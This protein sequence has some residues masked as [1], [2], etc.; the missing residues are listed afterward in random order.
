MPT[1][2]ALP[3]A[4]CGTALVQECLGPCLTWET[5]GQPSQTVA[6]LV[7][8]G[9]FHYVAGRTENEFLYVTMEPDGGSALWRSIDGGAP[10]EITSLPP[11]RLSMVSAMAAG[12]YGTWLV[13]SILSNGVNTNA[14]AYIVNTTNELAVASTKTQ[15]LY[16]TSNGVAR[17]SDYYVALTDGLYS[18]YPAG[19]S[20]LYFNPPTDSATITSIAVDDAEQ[21][22]YFVRGGSG[23]YA[24]WH[25]SFATNEATVLT[26]LPFDLVGYAM[27]VNALAL[28]DGW[29]YVLGVR[30]LVRLNLTTPTTLELVYAGE[31]FPQ[32]GGTLKQVGVRALGGKLYF[33]SICHFDA[34]APGYGTVELD[35]QALTARWLD[36]DPAFP[37][38]P[39][40]T[41][42]EAWSDE[43]PVYARPGGAYI[44]RQ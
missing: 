6:S 33:G 31:P 19:E 4:S 21:N 8:L 30:G 43:G 27:G 26:S 20:R 32:Y 41:S 10:A 17:G 16:P 29:L 23:G 11:G 13:G 18:F 9:S 3:E 25:F 1:L 40:V 7:E 36:L 37:R 14:I 38:V 2:A 42:S 12:T 5:A 28:H 22:I 24:V 34:D 39:F 15:T 44:M 35:P